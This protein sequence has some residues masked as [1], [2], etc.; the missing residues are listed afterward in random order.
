[1]LFAKILALAGLSA[2]ATVETS[3]VKGKAFDR[4]VVIYFENQNYEKAIG[5]RA[6]QSCTLSADEN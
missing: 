5:D 4:F 2:A 1:M 6:Y 3:N